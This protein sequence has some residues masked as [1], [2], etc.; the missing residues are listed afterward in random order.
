MASTSRNHHRGKSKREIFLGVQ[1][2]TFESGGP[3][4][5]WVVQ[6]KGGMAV[7]TI[8]EP[9]FAGKTMVVLVRLDETLINKLIASN[10]L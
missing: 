5:A 4:R 1:E 8:K 3:Y 7:L 9:Q 2:G 10:T 6:L